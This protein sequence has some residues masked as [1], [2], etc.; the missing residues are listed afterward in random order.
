MPYRQSSCYNLPN[1]R[2]RLF[3]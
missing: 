3:W 2:A 1:L